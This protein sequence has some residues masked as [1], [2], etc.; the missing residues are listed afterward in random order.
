MNEKPILFS[1][2]MVRALLAGTKTQT[3]RVMKPQPQRASTGTWFWSPNKNV[4]HVGDDGMF[5]IVVSCT[6]CPYGMSGDRL[7]V[8][9]T[10][11]NHALP[12]YPPVW[13][14]RADDARKPEDRKWRPSIFC[15]R[16]ASRITLEIT[17]VRVERL[18]DISEDDAKAEGG[19]A[20]LGFSDEQGQHGW[21]T[22]RQWY[23]WLWESINGK[24]S[25]DLNPWVWVIK[26]RRI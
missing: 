13:F 18:K 14:Y 12:G 11:L 21:G 25:W 24:G 3:R 17:A 4:H 6:S 8:R 15:T 26:F 9:E 1:G 16:S 5:Q 19:P 10:H 2:P 23:K 22:Y 20:V 7:W